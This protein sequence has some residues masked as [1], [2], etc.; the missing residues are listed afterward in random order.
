MLSKD[1]ERLRYAKYI[2]KIEELKHDQVNAGAMFGRASLDEIGRSYKNLVNRIEED[3]SL[4]EEHKKEILSRALEII[5]TLPKRDEEISRAEKNYV[6][7]FG[8]CSETEKEELK[9]I[10]EESSGRIRYPYKPKTK[11]SKL[12]GNLYSSEYFILFTP[13]ELK[14]IY[15]G[16]D[17]ALRTAYDR[18]KKEYPN[19]APDIEEEVDQ[20]LPKEKNKD[21][22]ER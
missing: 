3:N 6:E 18:I 1:A 11:Y 19:T 21:K 9:R 22:D 10:F 12:I 13:E 7:A 16:D 4:S 20:A 15:S 17:E 14:K 8:Q 5:D 2:V